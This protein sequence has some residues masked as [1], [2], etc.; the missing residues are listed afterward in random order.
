M[1]KV[2]LLFLIQ[3]LYTLV[4]SQKNAN[5]VIIPTSESYFAYCINNRFEVIARQ[6]TPITIDK[7]KARL[8]TSY[9]MNTYAPIYEELTLEEIGENKFKTPAFDFD[10]EVVIEFTIEM[11]SGI[12][13]IIQ[14]VKSMPVRF[15]I[16]ANSLGRDTSIQVNMLKEAEGIYAKIVYKDLNANAAVQQ[17]TL[18]GILDGKIQEEIINKGGR[19]SNESLNMIQQVKAGDIILIENI[20]YKVCSS[21]ARFDYAFILK[22]E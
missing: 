13:T 4:F 18:T 2:F 6:K 1:N 22:V 14:P 3:F 19:F 10:W 11:E 21:K 5:V 12:E 17:Y 15:K 7:I 9:D 16:S 20:H 8:I